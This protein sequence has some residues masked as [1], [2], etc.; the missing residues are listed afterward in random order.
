VSQLDLDLGSIKIAIAYGGGVNTIATAV[1][2]HQN[3]HIPTAMVMADPGSEWAHTIAYRDGVFAEWCDSVDFPRVTVV[4]RIDEGE[5]NPRAWRLETLRDECMRIESLP[6]IAYGW[7]KCSAKY[8]GDT[9]RWWF[10]RQPWAIAEWEAGKRIA[11]IIGYDAG[12]EYRVMDAF[13]NKWENERFVPWYPLFNAGLDRDGCINLIKSAGLPVPGKSACTYCPSNKIDEWKLLRKI[14]PA[15]FAEALA[16]SR[17]AQLQS[18]DVVG[19]MRCNPH[20]KRQL[21]EW[22]DGAY[23][24]IDDDAMEEQLPCECAL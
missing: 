18:P 19:L 16:M 17:N 11:K 15:R 3:G 10:S 23:G 5:H 22:A 20:G 2:C 13:Q 24:V 12:E 8:K 7:K 6:S 14:E 1:W 21:H 9:S 4:N